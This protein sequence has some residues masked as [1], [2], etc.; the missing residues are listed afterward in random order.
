M[1]RRNFLRWSSI[2]GAA[3]AFPA[4]PVL[5]AVSTGEKEN[6]PSPDSDRE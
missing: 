1:K 5:A 2:F 3:A 6:T 4:T